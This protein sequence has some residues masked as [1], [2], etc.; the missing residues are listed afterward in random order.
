MGR[1]DACDP[2]ASH[3]LHFGPSHL[4]SLRD[5]QVRARRRSLEPTK[6][7]GLVVDIF[8]LHPPDWQTTPR[9]SGSK[10]GCPKAF[11]SRSSSQNKMDMYGCIHHHTR[12]RC[13]V[14]SPQAVFFGTYITCSFFKSTEGLFFN[15]R[16][17]PSTTYPINLRA[18]CS[19]TFCAARSLG[20]RVPVLSSHQKQKKVTFSKSNKFDT[21]KSQDRHHYKDNMFTGVR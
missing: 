3:V 13:T 1:T 15:R 8:L 14:I 6:S 11:W 17:G 10:T 21:L 19:L 20:L 18:F 2:L 5:K 16:D 7:G 4:E 9:L 12:N